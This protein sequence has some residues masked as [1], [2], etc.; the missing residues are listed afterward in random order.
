MGSSITMKKALILMTLF[1]YLKYHKMSLLLNHLVVSYL[2]NYMKKILILIFFAF[3]SLVYSQTEY[4]YGYVTC[5]QVKICNIVLDT[6]I[7]TCSINDNNLKETFG[8]PDTIYVVDEP[9]KY[10]RYIYGQDVIDLPLNS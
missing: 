10:Q 4:E 6:S 7:L 9:Y 1:L 8:I 2:N 3:H 5:D